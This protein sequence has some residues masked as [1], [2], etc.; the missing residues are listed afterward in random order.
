[1]T[2]ASNATNAT[3]TNMGLNP[4]WF[5]IISPSAGAIAVDSA[6]ESP[7][8]PSPSPIRSQGMMSATHVEEAL[9]EAAWNN[10]CAVLRIMAK[11]IPQETKYPMGIAAIP[12]SPAVST[13]HLPLVSTSQPEKGRDAMEA[14]LNRAVATPIV[15]AS[16]PK[17]VTKNG[18]VGNNAWKFTKIKKFTKQILMKEPVHN[19]FC[20]IVLFMLLFFDVCTK[21]VSDHVK[22]TGFTCSDTT[23]CFSLLVVQRY[24]NN[25]SMQ[26]KKD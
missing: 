11:A 4:H 25:H 12:I 7:Y 22:P 16:P 2:S 6:I 8:I 13:A 9:L 20:P 1:M 5:I 14:T 17:Y 23:R 10:P 15:K 24:K 21:K 26:S 19:L 18:K 3:K